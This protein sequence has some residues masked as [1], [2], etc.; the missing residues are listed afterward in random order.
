MA[1][2]G[3]QL[4]DLEALRD[5]LTRTSEAIGNASTNATAETASVVGTVRDASTLALSRV[6]ATMDTL[7]GSVHESANRAANAGW[8]GANQVRFLEAHGE[9]TSAM[10]E[11]DAATREAFD[12]FQ[13]N[14][15]QMAETLESF[16]SNLQLSLTRATDSTQTM[17]RAVEGQRSNLDMAMN[18]GL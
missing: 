17:A 13:L 2:L 12:Q 10:G 14:V 7:S 5:Q 16:Q 18:Q 6:S 1:M 9:F 15:S 3:A 4:E 11:V 8:T